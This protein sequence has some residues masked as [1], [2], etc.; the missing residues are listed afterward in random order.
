MRPSRCPQGLWHSTG[1][2][3]ASRAMR[4][5]L[6]LFALSLLHCAHAPEAPVALPPP[7]AAAPEW[8]EPQP[9]ALRLPESVRPVHYELDLTLLPAE[10]TYSGTVTIELDVR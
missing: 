10:P 4:W 1:L 2:R 3:L 9:P 5:P 8:P 7:V 6:A